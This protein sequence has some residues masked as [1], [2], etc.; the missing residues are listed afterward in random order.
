MKWR[1]TTEKPRDKQLV[2]IVYQ[3]QIACEVF[4]FDGV[5]CVVADPVGSIAWCDVQ[6]WIG[7]GE[8]E[9][10]DWLK[11]QMKEHEDKMR[12]VVEIAAAYRQEKGDLFGTVVDPDDVVEGRI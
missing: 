2:L 12:S 8:L 10:P 6:A 7:L 9:G 3:D 4:V 11:G 1:H 5:K